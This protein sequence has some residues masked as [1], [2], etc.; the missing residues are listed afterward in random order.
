MNRKN[1][2][3]HSTKWSI[4]KSIEDND[5]YKILRVGGSADGIGPLMWLL[6]RSLANYGI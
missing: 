5:A 1:K 2:I 6:L 3:N 4:C